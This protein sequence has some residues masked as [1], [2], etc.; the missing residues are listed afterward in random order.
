MTDIKGFEWLYYDQNRG[1]YSS[2]ALQYEM[3]ANKQGQN[4]YGI[5]KLMDIY[6]TI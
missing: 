1:L 2:K 3:L 6:H 4:V 5:Q